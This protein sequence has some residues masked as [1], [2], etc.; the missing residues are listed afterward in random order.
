MSEDAELGPKLTPEE[1][2]E[3]R[4]LH[5]FEQTGNTLAPAIAHVKDSIRA[6]DRRDDI[7]PPKDDVVIGEEAELPVEVPKVVPRRVR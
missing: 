1:D 5:F 4:R 2:A 3:L 6:R 7:R